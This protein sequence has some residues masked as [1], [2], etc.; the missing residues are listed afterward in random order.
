[1]RGVDRSYLEIETGKKYPSLRVPRTV[2][3]WFN[4]SLS[5]RLYGL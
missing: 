4:L 1:M 3:D 5:Q 2:A